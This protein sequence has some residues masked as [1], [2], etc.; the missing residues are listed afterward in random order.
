MFSDEYEMPLNLKELATIFHFP[1]TIVSSQL[2]LAKAGIAPAPMEMG[3]EG[4]LLGINSYRGKDT[5][6]RMSREDRLRHMYV[7]GQTGTGKTTILKNMIA[8]DIKNGD[9]C[10]F[11]DPHGSDI[12]DILSYV[13]K[14][15]IDDVIYFDPAYTARPMGLNMLEYDPKYPEQKTFVVNELMTIFNKLFTK[16]SMGPMFEQY[17]KNSAFL[18]MDDP[19]NHATLLDITRIL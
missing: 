10:C 18:A 9:G 19:N 16:E 17:F 7:I 3:G 11:I 6:I 8:Q 14:E 4:I 15:R 5:E 13:P 12:Q 2:K 1:N